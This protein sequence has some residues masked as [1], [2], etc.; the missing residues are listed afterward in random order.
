MRRSDWSS[1]L[2]MERAWNAAPVRIPL[3][4]GEIIKESMAELDLSRIPADRRYPT[5][6]YMH[7]CSGLWRGTFRRIDFLAENGFAVIAPA[8]FARKKYPVS[9]DPETHRGGLYRGT[10]KM[11]QY[12]AG[13]AIKRAKKLSWVDPRNVFL[14]GLSQ[15]GITTATFSSNDP[16]ASVKARVIEG[17]TCH[18]GWPEYKGINAPASEPVLSLVGENDPWFQNSWSKGDCS[19]FMNSSNGSRSVV[20]RSGPL[21]DNHELLEDRSVQKTVIAFLKQMMEQSNL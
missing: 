5:V 17:W 18:A 3:A 19:R 14:M 16:L 11:R 12:D 9:C 21:S 2:E 6:I 15:G 10:L 1:Y 7:G 20:Y 8:S 4:N 13:F